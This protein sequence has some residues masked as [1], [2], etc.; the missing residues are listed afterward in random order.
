MSQGSG[1][2]TDV[3]AAS[4]LGIA[5][6]EQYLHEEQAHQREVLRRGLGVSLLSLL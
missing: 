2:G 4:S 1:R 3:A 6:W 5:D